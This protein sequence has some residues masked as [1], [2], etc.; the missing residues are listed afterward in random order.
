MGDPMFGD[1]SDTLGSIFWTS[2]FEGFVRFNLD[3]RRLHAWLQPHYASSDQT[4]NCPVIYVDLYSFLEASFHQ[5]G[6]VRW[7]N[8]HYLFLTWQLHL[9]TG[10]RVVRTISRLISISLVRY[11]LGFLLGLLSSLFGGR[12]GRLCV[13]LTLHLRRGGVLV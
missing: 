9:C 1:V 10:V 8:L 4:S 5:C 6:V 12:L 3:S 7:S 2:E 11:L 13:W